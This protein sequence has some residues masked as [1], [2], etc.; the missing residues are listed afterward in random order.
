MKRFIFSLWFIAVLTS[1]SVVNRT[2]VRDYNEQI[3]LT[4]R[5]FPELY[6]LYWRGSI[7]I[8]SVYT[9]EEN[10]EKKVGILYSYR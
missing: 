5:Y 4:K 2:Y 8:T 3:E 9:Y 1:C 6:D 7:I 10:G